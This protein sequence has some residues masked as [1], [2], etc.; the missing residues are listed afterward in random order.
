ML[1]LWQIATITAMFASSAF[2]FVF[3][4]CLQLEGK[5]S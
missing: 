4:R 1:E 5:K 3:A 2:L